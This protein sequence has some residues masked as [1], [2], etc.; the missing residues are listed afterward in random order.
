MGKEQRLAKRL[1]LITLGLIL[2]LG[3]LFLVLRVEDRDL[4]VDARKEADGEFVSLT[5]GLTHYHLAGSGDAP[6]VVLIHGFS[7]PDYVW[8]PTYTA[9]DEAGFRVL[10]YDLYGRGYSDRPDLVYDIDLFQNQ[11]EDLLTAL[12]VNSPVNL[13]GLSMGAP[14][15]ARFAHQHPDRVKSLILIAPEVT[16][17]TSRDIFPMNLPGL[18]EYLMAAVMEPIVLPKLQPGDFYQPDNFPGWENR[19]R[20]QLHFRGTSRALL[21]T[22]RSL[23]DLDPELDY[24]YIEKTNLPVLLVWGDQDQTISRDQIE[25]LRAILPD[26]DLLIVENAGHL[27]HYEQPEVVNPALIDFLESIPQ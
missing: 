6:L 1:G 25:V 16:Q 10:S 18:G 26:M 11:L 14:I 22:I 23:I 2:V 21:S 3:G 9:L 12:D 8:E 13:V 4:D 5:D 20:D 27:P 24:Q 7:V 17:T 19:Y 15:A